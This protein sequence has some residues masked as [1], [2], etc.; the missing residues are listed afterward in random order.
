MILIQDTL[1]IYLMS[2]MHE[3]DSAPAS[4][5]C[6]DLWSHVVPI[7]LSLLHYNSHPKLSCC[8]HPIQLTSRMNM[9]RTQEERT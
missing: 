1:H 3:F 9:H 2:Q 7:I 5:Y 6:V 8:I 4:N